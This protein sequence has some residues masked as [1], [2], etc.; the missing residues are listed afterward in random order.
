[1]IHIHTNVIL[2]LKADKMN[3]SIAVDSYSL[4]VVCIRLYSLA[5][6]FGI[7]RR[8]VL[9]GDFPLLS[10]PPSSLFLLSPYSSPQVPLYFLFPPTNSPSSASAS[11][12]PPNASA[13]HRTRTHTSVSPTAY[14]LPQSEVSEWWG[15]SWGSNEGLELRAWQGA[16]CTVTPRRERQR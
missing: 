7:E 1:M 5:A 3:L 2:T 4:L 16:I 10:L 13:P 6:Q 12:P 14:L 15:S 11:Q 8:A 9:T